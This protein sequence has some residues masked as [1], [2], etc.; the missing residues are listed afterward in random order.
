M[1]HAG[2]NY[3][4][5]GKNSDAKELFDK[6]KKDFNSSSAFREVDKYSV[7]LEQ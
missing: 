5:A 7:Q 2:I 1:L 6:I 3:M 4:A